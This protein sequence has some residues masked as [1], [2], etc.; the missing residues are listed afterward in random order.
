DH[1]RIGIIGA[2]NIGGN[3]ARRFRALGHEVLIAN[4]RGPETL[5]DFA[6]GIGAKAVTAPEAARN[7]D[8]VVITI[9]E[10]AVA[11]LPKDLFSGVPDDVVVIDTCNYYSAR[12]G[13]IAAIE[14]GQPESAWV[15][16]Q[17]GR[18]VVKA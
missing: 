5:Q 13:R 3:L 17:L 12:D 14:D 1:M 2:G 11:E 18:P 15:A 10:K 4:S 8:V 6:A 7:G 16:Q 9:P